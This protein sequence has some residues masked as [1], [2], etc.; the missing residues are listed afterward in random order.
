MIPDERLQQLIEGKDSDEALKWCQEHQ[1][2]ESWSIIDGA[3]VIYNFEDPPHWLLPVLEAQDEDGNTTIE[4]VELQRII[5]QE[6]DC[7]EKRARLE[8]EGIAQA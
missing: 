4:R 5:L 2:G 1:Y 6:P 3:L 7:E 8:A